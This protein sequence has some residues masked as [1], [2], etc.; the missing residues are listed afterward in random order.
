MEIRT[1]TKITEANDALAEVNRQ[2]LISHKILCIN[3]IG[4]PGSGKTSV[5]ESII[6]ALTEAGYKSA[7]IEGDMC[8]NADAERIGVLGVPVVQVNTENM[9]GACHLDANMVKAAQE[10]LPLGG[11]SFL[12]VEN[13]GN[14]VC[15]AEFD[16][17]ETFKAVVLSAA[18]GDDKPSKYPLAFSVARMMILNK[19]DLIP[20]TN[21]DREKAVRDARA[22]NSDMEVYEIST[23]THEGITQL[24]RRLV[25]LYLEKFQ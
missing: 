20:Y 10:N 12:F 1:L 18:E 14:L 7:V 8:T 16:V 6:P 23:R 24:V 19:T 22:L 3:L 9:G 2:F 15:P 17:G 5:L 11:I 21:F 25:A 13:V 4:S